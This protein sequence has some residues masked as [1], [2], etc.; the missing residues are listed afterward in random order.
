MSYK[1]LP[2]INENSSDIVI[3]K[4]ILKRSKD[5]ASTQIMYLYSCL[6]HKGI[7]ATRK[8]FS[9]YPK[10]TAL[11]LIIDTEIAQNNTYVVPKTVELYWFFVLKHYEKD[12]KSPDGMAVLDKSL[13]LT[14][15][16]LFKQESL[17]ASGFTFDVNRYIEMSNQN[18]D[19]PTEEIKGLTFKSTN[20]TAVGFT[21]WEEFK[22]YVAHLLGT[23]SAAITPVYIG[24]HTSGMT[25]EEKYKFHLCNSPY[26]QVY[27]ET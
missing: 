18:Y 10:N 14:S 9:T 4:T 20:A 7:D 17:K 8:A 23:V 25:E 13:M 1:L 21:C 3:F 24:K 16:I 19:I 27:D 11:S 5:L 12:D 6:L 22:A 15:L 2:F 26:M